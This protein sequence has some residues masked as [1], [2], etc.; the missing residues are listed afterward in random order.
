MDLKNAT[1]NFAT[2]VAEQADIKLDLN[3]HL[4]DKPAATYFVRVKGSSLTKQG[5]H[6]NDLLI[7][8]RSLPVINNALVIATID[9]SFT[10]RRVSKTHS[11]IYLTSLDYNSQKRNP[12]D[13]FQIWGTVT[14]IIHKSL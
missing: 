4:I 1:V 2:P 12:L 14:Y 5:I 6:E 11:K 8:D 10:L 3:Q 13:D 7:V 9:N